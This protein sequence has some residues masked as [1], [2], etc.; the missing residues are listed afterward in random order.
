MLHKIN[1]D[2]L[3]IA[4][5]QTEQE[6]IP[7]LEE[8][9]AQDEKTEIIT[10][11]RRR[12]TPHHEVSNRNVPDEYMVTRE[13]ALDFFEYYEKNKAL[14][15][16]IPATYAQCY[17]ENKVVLQTR[18]NALREILQHNLNKQAEERISRKHRVKL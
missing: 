16:N 14:F 4:I 5:T 13:L 11:E 7:A 1:P 12:E 2:L 15:Q 6:L 10:L 3:E 18:V 8:K 17:E 9:I